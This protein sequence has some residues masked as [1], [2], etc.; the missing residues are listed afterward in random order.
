[1]SGTREPTTPERKEGCYDW[2]HPAK[3]GHSFTNSW[4]LPDTVAA[5]VVAARLVKH[6]LAAYGNAV[7]AA[8]QPCSC[9][10]AFHALLR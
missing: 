2:V 3:Y 1:M 4:V 9:A 8:S 7:H 6:P 5:S 10:F